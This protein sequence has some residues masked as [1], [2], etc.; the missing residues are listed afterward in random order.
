MQEAL[1]PI[2]V[3]SLCFKVLQ[4]VYR[5]MNALNLFLSPIKNNAPQGKRFFPLSLCTA[6]LSPSLVEVSGSS[7]SLFFYVAF[8]NVLLK[9]KLQVM[10]IYNKLFFHTSST[11]VTINIFAKMAGFSSVK[12]RKKNHGVRLFLQSEGTFVEHLGVL[13]PA[14]SAI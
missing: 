8:W 1:N 12:E 6:E 4:E 2:I 3:D 11:E 13:S 7:M 9:Q 5:T 10:K 14:F